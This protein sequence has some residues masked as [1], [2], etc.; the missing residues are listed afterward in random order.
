MQFHKDFI[1]SGWIELCG[2]GRKC[3]VSRG[4]H[5]YHEDRMCGARRKGV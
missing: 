2:V 4:S 5:P 1:W 3:A